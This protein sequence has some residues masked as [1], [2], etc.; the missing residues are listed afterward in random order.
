MS[1]GGSGQFDDVVSQAAPATRVP[2][3]SSAAVLATTGTISGGDCREIITLENLGPNN[4]YYDYDN[5]V[6]DTTSSVLRRNQIVTM[7]LGGRIT[8]YLRCATG[9]T[10]VVVVE[11]FYQEDV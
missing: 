8:V 3:D 2:V 10:A 7:P 1:L 5:S 4:V 9:Q 6:S 11:E